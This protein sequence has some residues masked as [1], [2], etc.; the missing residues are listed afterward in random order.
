MLHVCVAVFSKLPG[1]IQSFS[2]RPGSKVEHLAW[3]NFQLAQLEAKALFIAI[4]DAKQKAQSMAKAL[5]SCLGEALLINAGDADDKKGSDV[6][7]FTRVE[8]RLKWCFAW[9]PFNTKTP[10]ILR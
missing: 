9:C 5:G 7:P 8:K 6:P 3:S 4:T 1:L 2:S 10:L